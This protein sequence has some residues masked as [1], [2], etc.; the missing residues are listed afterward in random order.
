[1]TNDERLMNNALN[2][3][4]GVLKAHK[5]TQSK[6]LPD[7]VMAAEAQLDIIRKAAADARLSILQLRNRLNEL[8][9]GT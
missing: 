4:E 2:A 5:L 9:T 6:S 7:T 3:L 1:M 8:K